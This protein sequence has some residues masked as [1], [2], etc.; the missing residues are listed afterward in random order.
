MKEQPDKTIG[1]YCYDCPHLEL[2]EKIKAILDKN[3]NHP[4][5]SLAM[6]TW[7]WIY[8]HF[9]EREVIKTLINKKN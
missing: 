3:V 9:V 2:R 7:E 6:I 1:Q 4:P 8:E 5:M